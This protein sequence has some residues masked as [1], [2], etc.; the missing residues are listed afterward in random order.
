LVLGRSVFEPDG[1]EA[2]LKFTDVNAPK[3]TLRADGGITLDGNTTISDGDKLQYGTTAATYPTPAANNEYITRGWADATFKPTG[4]APAWGDVT[5]KPFSTIGS[6]L[7][8]TDGVLSANTSGDFMKLTGGN[9][10]SGAQTGTLGN[11]EAFQLTGSGTNKMYFNLTPGKD[12]RAGDNATFV[13]VDSSSVSLFANSG[14]NYATFYAYPAGNIFTRAD[15]GFV[16]DGDVVIN[17]GHKLGWNSV[18]SSTYPTPTA[19]SEYVT[20]G[21][22]DLT[23]VTKAGT[24]AFTGTNSFTNLPTSN[25]IPTASNQLVTKV[26]VDGVIDARH[27]RNFIA[28]TG[29]NMSYSSDGV[30]WRGT[31]DNVLNCIRALN[32]QYIMIRGNDMVY[33]SLNGKDWA[34]QF[35][36]GS[37]TMYDLTYREGWYVA[38]VGYGVYI[39]STLTAWSY[40]ETFQG[41]SMQDITSG[42]QGYAA[43]HWNRNTIYTATDERALSW[44]AYP[45]SGPSGFNDVAYGNGVYVAAGYQGYCSY[46]VNLTNWI[47][48]QLDNTETWQVVT[49]SDELH[50]WV[51]LGK[52][53]FAYSND[54]ISWTLGNLPTEFPTLNDLTYGEGVF[55]AVGGGNTFLWSENGTAW[56]VSYMPA[57]DYI[58]I[59][60]LHIP[61]QEELLLQRIEALERRSLRWWQWVLPPFFWWR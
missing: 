36:G 20:K 8:V 34:S 51:M 39:S 35:A 45:I 21:W 43:V 44:T 27:P 40:K 33:T 56:A 29:S 59:A 6:G 22:T 31:G 47:T 11:N 18:S 48:K 14:T 32:G 38:L 17:T 46:S 58:A 3:A 2:S 13:N 53:K 60:H 61:T 16:L 49:Y 30:A 57:N 37:Y 1:V 25:A 28:I 55:V 19:N 54:G 7:A 41:N 5:G 4:Y 10:F 24:N 26:Y 9:T 23:Y 50:R 52:K 12:F 15:K 42:P